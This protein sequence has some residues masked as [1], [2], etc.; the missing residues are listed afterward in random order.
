MFSVPQNPKQ[1]ELWLKACYR[2]DLLPKIKTFQRSSRYRLCQLH[3]EDKFIS[4]AG[5]QKR[6]FQNAVPSLFPAKV[7]KQSQSAIGSTHNESLKSDT[8]SGVYYLQ[9][10][11]T[12]IVIKIKDIASELAE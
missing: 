8:L 12:I 11:D 4:K 1:A 2:T 10:F 9:F 7:T 6:L 3:F 5:T